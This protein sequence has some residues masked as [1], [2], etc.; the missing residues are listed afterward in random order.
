MLR[1]H[2]G[3]ADM[4]GIHKSEHGRARARGSI[5]R[6]IRDPNRR[7][8]P[9]CQTPKVRLKEVGGR[10]GERGPRGGGGSPAGGGKEGQSARA[11]EGEREK[12]KEEEEE[13]EEMQ[14]AQQTLH[15]R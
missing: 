4:L 8:P 3:D 10:G 2:R 13:E 9:R 12:E 7:T 6:A 1:G 5:I 14:D 15:V 11:R